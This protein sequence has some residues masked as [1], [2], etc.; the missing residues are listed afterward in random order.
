MCLT[1]RIQL[2]ANG[3]QVPDLSQ[4][5]PYILSLSQDSTPLHL[6]EKLLCSKTLFVKACAVSKKYL[7][8]TA[9]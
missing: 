7:A 5:D 8:Y 6:F 3:V 9:E 1:K 4:Q 2:D